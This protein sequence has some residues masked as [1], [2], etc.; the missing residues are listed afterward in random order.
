[1]SEFRKWTLHFDDG[2]NIIDGK[3]VQD[4]PGFAAGGGKEL[5][6]A[7]RAERPRHGHI[8]TTCIWSAGHSWHKQQTSE[9]GCGP[10]EAKTAGCKAVGCLLTAGDIIAMQQ[11]SVKMEHQHVGHDV[12]GY[13]LFQASR[14]PVLHD[15][16]ER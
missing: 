2:N 11:T 5:V 15:V 1:M 10:S 4:P 16:D 8:F 13:R 3:R 14:L 6:S 12:K 9:H 7:F